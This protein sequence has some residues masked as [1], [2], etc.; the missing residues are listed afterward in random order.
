[1]T[2]IRSNPPAGLLSRETLI[3]LFCDSRNTHRL[4]FFNSVWLPGIPINHYSDDAS[5]CML[6]STPTSLTFFKQKNPC[7][8]W[9]WPF[10]KPI[11]ELYFM[12][13]A[14]TYKSCKQPTVSSL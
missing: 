5:A 2:E 9:L 11:Y 3:T 13:E 8:V 6:V 7:F 4:F 12:Q 10:S 14:K 1:M